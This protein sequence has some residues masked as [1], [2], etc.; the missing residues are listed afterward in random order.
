MDKKE[1]DEQ[2][3]RERKQNR[4][5]MD[6]VAATFVKNVAKVIKDHRTDKGYSQD[7]LALGIGQHKSVI[8]KYE[9]GEGEISASVMAKISVF[10][11]FPL[12]EYTNDVLNKELGDKPEDIYF[13][14]IKINEAKRTEE[15]E[16]ELHRPLSKPAAESATFQD[17]SIKVPRQ[18]TI[19]DYLDENK[20]LVLPPTT[21]GE[22]F[23]QGFQSTE[24]EKKHRKPKKYKG[25]GYVKASEEE[26]ME[27]ESFLMETT[28]MMPLYKKA[29]IT[30]IY[31]AIATQI[32]EVQGDDLKELSQIAK[33]TIKYAINDAPARQ[34]KHIEA[35]LDYM[36][37]GNLAYKYA[38]YPQWQRPEE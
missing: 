13:A 17:M 14:L 20:R 1:R 32:E 18:M 2:R 36:S 31:Q 26:L 9:R 30:N 24:K 21:E 12:K 27:A 28:E 19:E 15:I 6:Y 23:M 8:G 29:T 16:K 7:D 3:E 4:I 22:P 38:E 33:A 37:D 25:Y 11:K 34:R 10:L 5:R 35:Y